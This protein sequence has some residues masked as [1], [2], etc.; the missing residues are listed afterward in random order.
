MGLR[1]DSQGGGRE[2]CDHDDGHGAHQR[3]G[4]DGRSGEPVRV[5]RCCD[6]DDAQVAARSAR[7]HDL[8]PQG[9]ARLRAQDQR[10]GVPRSAGRSAR[11]PDRGHRD[12]AE[13]SGV[14]RVQGV[15]RAGQEEREGAGAGADGHGIH[16]LHERHGQPSS[17]VGRASAGSDGLE[18]REGVRSDQ[19]LAE[20]EHGARRQVGAVARRCA[21]R[22]ARADDA[23][24]E[25]G[26]LQEGGGIPGSRCEDLPGRAEEL[27]KEAEG[28]RGGAAEQQGHP[29]IG[30]RS[31][32][33]RHLVPDARIRYGN[34]EIQKSVISFKWL[35]V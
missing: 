32:G 18:D 13:G 16:D 7:R 10:R 5:L 19:H 26:G 25:G 2:R 20:Q 28:L 1:S 11:S 29:C 3:S 23:R 27:R 33:V 22:N 31:C 34:D 12:A 21:H 8:L 15:L 4:G 24:T 17:A 6:D 35:F 9:R 14:A 30:S